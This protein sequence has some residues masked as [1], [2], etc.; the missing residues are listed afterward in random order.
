MANGNKILNKIRRDQDIIK[1]KLMRK[2]RV[3]NGG[4]RQKVP[5]TDNNG[6]RRMTGRSKRGRKYTSIGCNV[7]GSTSIKIPVLLR[8]LLKRHGLEVGRQVLLIPTLGQGGMDNGA[9]RRWNAPLTGPLAGRPGEVSLLL[10]LRRQR[11]TRWRWGPRT[12][13]HVY[14]AGPRIVVAGSRGRL[15]R[16]RTPEGTLRATRRGGVATALVVALAALLETAPGA[17]GGRLLL[18]L[19]WL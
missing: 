8:R 13:P 11:R 14:G 2:N 17:R 9:G 12:W 6:R 19:W 15:S 3:A 4:D 16:S 5:I 7:T 18:L 1:M 10:L